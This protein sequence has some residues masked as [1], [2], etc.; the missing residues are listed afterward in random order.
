MTV[1]TATKS[2]TFCQPFSLKGADGLQPAGTYAVET[3][4]EAVPALSFL[5]YRRPST[6]IVCLLDTEAL[7]YGR[8]SRSIQR[9]SKR[10]R[11]ETKT[12]QA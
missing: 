4:E 2:V 3:E 1:R 7:S 5:A 9:T 12:E 10:L 6:A 8:W 11:H